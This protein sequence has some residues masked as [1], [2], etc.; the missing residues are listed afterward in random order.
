MDKIESLHGK[1]TKTYD[2][3]RHIHSKYYGSGSEYWD[4]PGTNDMIMSQRMNDE[5]NR[6]FMQQMQ[7]D[8]DTAM[9]M[10]TG[11]EFGGYNCDPNLNPGM[12]YAND[13]SF[14]NDMGFGND[15]GTFGGMGFW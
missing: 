12:D 3:S 13:M 10:A 9:K 1:R 15:M 2:R 4:V 11:I 7:E 8:S 5:A 14:S 6:Q